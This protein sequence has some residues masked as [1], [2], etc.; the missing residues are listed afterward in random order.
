[1]ATF[2]CGFGNLFL[3][4][5]FFL[6]HTF[7]TE[8][9]NSNW[10]ISLQ[11]DKQNNLFIPKKKLISICFKFQ[12]LSNGTR[13]NA[14]I[15]TIFVLTLQA[16]DVN[17]HLL[18]AKSDWCQFLFKYDFPLFSPKAYQISVPYLF[19]LIL[20]KDFLFYFVYN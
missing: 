16:I 15:I 20:T 2:L 5:F 10:I 13:F 4:Y 18:H 12:Q 19:F 6:I 7:N 1:M 9:G 3:F 14:T 17:N 11:K 8:F